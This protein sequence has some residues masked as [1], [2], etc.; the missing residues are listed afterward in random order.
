VT[1]AGSATDA[2]DGDVTASLIWVSDL[3]GPIGSGAGFSLSS[4]SVGTHG[5][6]ATAVDGDGNEGSAGISVV[7]NPNAQPVVVITAP[8]SGS[9]F[10]DTE[11]ITFT[12]SA[13]DDEDGDLTASI[14]WTLPPSILVGTGG[15]FE[16]T[17]LPEGTHVITASVTDSHGAAGT[18]DVTVTV[19][20]NSPPVV[21]ISAP[22]DGAISTET[23][24]VTFTGSATDTEEGDL[25]SSLAWTSSLDGA[26]GSGASFS[27]TTL[28]P[29]THL[30]TA[31]L[32]DGG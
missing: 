5:I 16:L 15:T 20:V 23:D 27:L 19:G 32:S 12:G 18:A 8:T 11:S 6:V 28:S 21:A 13:S 31:S 2:Q 24:S 30:I 22:A 17:N 26:I 4:L 14:S 7:V 9:V 25:S 1:F 10:T 3:D 29:G